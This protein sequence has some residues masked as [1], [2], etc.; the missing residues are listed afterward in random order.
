VFLEKG[1]N[2]TPEQF[3]VMDTL[4]DEGILTQQQIADI[5]MRDKNSIVKLI[6]GLEARNLVKRVNNPKDKRQNLIKVTEYS[7]TVKDAVTAISYEAVQK[8]INGI[9]RE[10]LESFVRTIA[11]M[12]KN[13]DKDSDLEELGRKY[14]TNPGGAI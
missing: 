2:L 13:I 8:I 6:D 9:P 7:K 3:L 1:Y 12:Q 4:W 11:R 14:P 5:T 10:E